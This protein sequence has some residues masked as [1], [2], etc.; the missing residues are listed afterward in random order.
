VIRKHVFILNFRVYE[1]LNVD[2]ILIDI[3]KMSSLNRIQTLL[4]IMLLR[5]MNE[6]ILIYEEYGLEMDE[7]A[8]LHHDHINQLG[9]HYNDIETAFF[10]DDKLGVKEAMTQMLYTVDEMSDNI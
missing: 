8:V 3:S 6:D 7:L 2:N 4:T 5:L 1:N 10:E 9:L